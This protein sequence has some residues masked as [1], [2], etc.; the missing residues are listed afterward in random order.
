MTCQ[1][2]VVEVTRLV[3]DG[4]KNACSMLYAAA[5]RVAKE[6]GYQRIQTFIMADEPGTSL[7]A[8]GWTDDGESGG[9]DWTRTSKPNRRQ[10]QPQCPKRRYVK[11]L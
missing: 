7:K 5:A 2:T 11:M 8:A 1:K 6:L 10:D 4:T 3:T 9:G